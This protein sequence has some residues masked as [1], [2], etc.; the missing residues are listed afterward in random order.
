MAH[1]D[2]VDRT[3]ERFGLSIPG[4]LPL[5]YANTRNDFSA[6]E[7]GQTLQIAQDPR[8]GARSRCRREQDDRLSLPD[9]LVNSAHPIE[10]ILPSRG[11][12]SIMLRER[13]DDAIAPAYGF[14]ECLRRLRNAG[15]C[16][17]VN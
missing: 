5:T 12:G 9:L 13:S 4:L 2:F 17:A 16:L 11:D 8:T 6:E 7:G 10:E 1:R 3:C 14:E 15:L